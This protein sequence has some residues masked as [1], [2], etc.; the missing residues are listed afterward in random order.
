MQNFNVSQNSPFNYDYFFIR[1]L[2]NIFDNENAPD[3]S[4]VF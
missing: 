1:R 3:Q 4:S 2:K